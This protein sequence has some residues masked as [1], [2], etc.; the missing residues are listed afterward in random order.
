MFWIC[1]IKEKNHNI[2]GHLKLT[3]KK[4]K[5][6]KIE[7]IYFCKEKNIFIYSIAL[8]TMFVDQIC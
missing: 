7:C 2:I 1:E 5:K 8:S 6:K 4:K 3:T